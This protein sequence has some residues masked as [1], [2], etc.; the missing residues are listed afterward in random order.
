MTERLSLRAVF[1][2]R[3]GTLGRFL[4]GSEPG[5]FELQLP[6]DFDADSLVGAEVDLE[7]CGVV[8]AED[9]SIV[10]GELVS[11]WPLE[12]GEP[13]LAWGSWFAQNCDWSDAADVASELG[14]DPFEPKG[15]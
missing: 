8:R 2:S 11:A 3:D 1:L 15:S 13:S 7:A 5:E 4:S 9:G 12:R 6:A 10:G 14:R